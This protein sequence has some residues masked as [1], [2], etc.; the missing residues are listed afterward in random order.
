[1]ITKHHF[2]LPFANSEH[3]QT[4]WGASMCTTHLGF[5][6]LSSPHGDQREQRIRETMFHERLDLPA[7]MALGAQRG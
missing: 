7:P 3:V 6:S 1:M 5:I 4:P 2:S